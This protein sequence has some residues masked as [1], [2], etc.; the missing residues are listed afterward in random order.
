MSGSGILKV[1]G[2][3]QQHQHDPEEKLAWRKIS[4]SLKLDGEKYEVSV[5]WKNEL[6]S[7]P[8]SRRL[9]ERR[10]QST[11]QKLAKYTSVAQVFQEVIDN[12]LDKSY[13]RE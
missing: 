13:L 9:A 4:S 11:E 8:S 6:P 7:L 2:Y 12:Y 1:W 5:S 3:G 10:L